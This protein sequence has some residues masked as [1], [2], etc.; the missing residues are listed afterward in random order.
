[1]APG[2]A[3]SHQLEHPKSLRLGIRADA[4]VLS[5]TYD[6][7]PGEPSRLLRGLFDR[8][9]SGQLEPAEQAM[10]TRYLEDTARLWLVLEA[11]GRPLTW[12]TRSREGARLDQPAAS[13]GSVGLSLVLTASVAMGAELRLRLADRDRDTRKHV[14]AVVDVAPGLRLRYASRGEWH[15]TLRQL[16]QVRLSPGVDLQLWLVPER[17]P[18]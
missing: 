12:Q 18:T 9:A 2:A 5:V 11:D 3:I 8:D 17:P 13:T 15:T 6:V 10:V 1:L 16:H 7:D 4:V 14:P